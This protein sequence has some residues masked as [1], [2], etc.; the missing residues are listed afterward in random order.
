M[1]MSRPEL[2]GHL[3]ALIRLNGGR[4]TK[5]DTGPVRQTFKSLRKNKKKGKAK[6]GR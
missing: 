5:K 1:A 3:D 2:D 6:H 4:A